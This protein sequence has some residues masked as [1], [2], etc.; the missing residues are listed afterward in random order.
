MYRF[1]EYLI[2]VHTRYS[3]LCTRFHA[4]IIS[5][6]TDNPDKKSTEQRM[7][8][9]RFL[10]T[11]RAFNAMK[12]FKTVETT[13]ERSSAFLESTQSKKKDRTT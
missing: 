12:I 9:L 8:G 7:I 2:H 6:I 11:K 1:T 13:L 3:V 5:L 4:Q 10:K